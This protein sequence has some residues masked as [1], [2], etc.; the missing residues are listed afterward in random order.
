MDYK[1]LLQKYM[2]HIASNEGMPY[3]EDWCRENSSESVN[4]TDDEWNELKRVFE[5]DDPQ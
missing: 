4:I 5:L 2:N 3:L 1:K